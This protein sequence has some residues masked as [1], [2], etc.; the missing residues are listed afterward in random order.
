MATELNKLEQEIAR[1][2]KTRDELLA[3]ER[4][5][6]LQQINEMIQTYQVLPKEVRF[7]ATR[8]KYERVQVKAMYARDAAKKKANGIEKV[9]KPKPKPATKAKGN[10]KLPPKYKLGEN[11]WSGKARKP[12]WVQQHLAKGGTLEAIQIQ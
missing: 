2:A 10:G 8:R 5:A 11:T 7:V 12:A 1:L 9:A 3:K 6:V 4:P